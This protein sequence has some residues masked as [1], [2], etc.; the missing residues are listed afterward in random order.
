MEFDAWAACL[1]EEEMKTMR[2]EKDEWGIGGSCPRG[3]R[4]WG[5]RIIS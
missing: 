3:G 2:A 1:V 5:P 4:K